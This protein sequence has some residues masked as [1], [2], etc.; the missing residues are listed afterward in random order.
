MTLARTKSMSPS[1]TRTRGLRMKLQI[2]ENL[3]SWTSH[4]AA[5][6]GE[7]QI[8]QGALLR[9]RGPLGQRASRSQGGF[10][11]ERAMSSRSG[12]WRKKATSHPGRSGSEKF[13][14]PVVDQ[15]CLNASKLCLPCM[16]GRERAGHYEQSS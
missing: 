8:K 14:V 11:S 15:R 5:V 12:L 10:E 1:Y 3:E 4:P 2:K 9:A 16:N 7:G 13:I 6:K